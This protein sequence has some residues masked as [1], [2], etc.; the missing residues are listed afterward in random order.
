[1]MQK[2]FVIFVFLFIGLATAFLLSEGSMATT[3]I[4][5][6]FYSNKEEVKSVEAGPPLV[7]NADQFTDLE[8][9]P[10][11]SGTWRR[12]IVKGKLP[13]N[14]PSS[15]G[16]NVRNN[17]IT[18]MVALSILVAALWYWA[19][20]KRANDVSRQ[21]PDA[22]KEPSQKQVEKENLT[23]QTEALSLSSMNEVRV[24]FKQWENRLSPN[25]KRNKSETISEWFHRINGPVEVIPLYEKVRYGYADFTKEELERFISILK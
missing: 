15:K 14:I 9:P 12:I 5:K 22:F 8:E 17:I 13:V 3:S 20:K 6:H 10:D 25:K 18:V 19:K 7:V 24:T 4:I 21:A 2:T 23:V 16:S 11:H 1:M